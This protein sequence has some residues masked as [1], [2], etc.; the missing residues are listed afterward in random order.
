[1]SVYPEGAN[2]TEV[3]QSMKNVLKKAGFISIEFMI[4]AGIVLLIGVVAVS[5]FATKGKSASTKA[6]TAIDSAF[7]ESGVNP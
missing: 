7:T 1:M 6:N 3:A 2:L 5:S 4:I